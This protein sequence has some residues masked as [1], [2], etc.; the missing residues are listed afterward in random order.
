MRVVCAPD[1]FKESMTA[2]QAA[3]AMAHGVRRVWP[4][5]DVTACPMADGGEGTMQTL[6]SALGGE[7]RE[8]P[9]H[10]ALGRPRMGRIGLVGRVGGDDEG[11]TAI[12]EM[13]E[14]AGLEHIEPAQRDVLGATSFGVGELIL[15]A[16]DAGARTLIVGIGG[17]ATNDAG[18][19]L[20]VALGARLL[21]IDGREIPLGAGALVDLAEVDLSGL[22]PRLA[23]V[24]VQV[25]CDVDNPLLGERGA[26]AVFGP[27]KG[28]SAKDVVV[29]ERGL[30][31]W[32]DVVERTTGRRVRESSGSGA[33][34]GLGACLM[35]MCHARVESGATVVARAI[36]LEQAIA[37]ADLVL[38]GEGAFDA[39]S[40]AGKVPVK[41][42]QMAAELGV[43]SIVCAGRVEKQGGSALPE[44]VIEAVQI[45]PEGTERSCAL[46]EGAANLERATEEVCRRFVREL[47][48]AP[49]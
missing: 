27:Q 28:A 15:A 3:M 31:R 14:A 26:S 37:H 21:S 6:V 10:D 32:A 13:A 8:V 24:S 2:P 42:A 17:S 30:T 29:L 1:S 35:A 39:Q 23:E 16:L 45:T 18:A 7:I 12:I 5:A 43:P 49:E 44:G 9:V 20:M 22:D 48:R 41:V 19:G 46:A 34:G 4:D 38:T 33:A 40:A 11:P 47:V 36:G 25:A